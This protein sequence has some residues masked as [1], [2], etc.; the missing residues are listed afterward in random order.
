M[1]YHHHGI[2]TGFSGNY[3][4]YFGMA[5][6][7]DAVVYL[8]LANKLIKSLKS[9]LISIAEGTLLRFLPHCGALCSC[10]ISLA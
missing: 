8:M 6:D 2:G 5:T 4:E 9:D 1:L 7:M 3:N 10:I